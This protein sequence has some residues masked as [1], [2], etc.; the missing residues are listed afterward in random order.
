MT[1]TILLDLVLCCSVP[2]TRGKLLA[3][4]VELLVRSLHNWLPISQMI[5]RSPEDRNPASCQLPST[6][7][8]FHMLAWPVAGTR[9]AV[10]KANTLY[11]TYLILDNRR[12]LDIGVFPLRVIRFTSR[13]IFFPPEIGC[14]PVRSS[15]STTPKLYTSLLSVSWCVRKYSGSKYP[16]KHQISKFK[17]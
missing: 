6:T 17:I 8:H 12:L 16:C 9:H 15:K 1:S 5:L 14:M 10:N 2:P 4:E 13:T 3:S 7:L 11:T